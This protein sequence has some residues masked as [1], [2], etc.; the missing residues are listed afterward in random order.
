MAGIIGG[1]KFITIS[2]TRIPERE[3]QLN[4]AFTAIYDVPCQVQL[5]TEIGAIVYY[6]FLCC[7]IYNT[8]RNW[9][10]RRYTFGNFPKENYL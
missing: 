4:G 3:G 1:M 8:A 10:I 9:F 5:S 7:K 2:Q 6:Q